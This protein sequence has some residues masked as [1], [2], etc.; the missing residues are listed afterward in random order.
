MWR[1]HLLNSFIIVGLESSRKVVPQTN[2]HCG[3][4]ASEKPQR[5]KNGKK[6]VTFGLGEQCGLG[7]RLLGPVRWST[8]NT[9][10]RTWLVD[11]PTQRSA[12]KFP[13]ERQPHALPSD[14]DVFRGCIGTGGPSPVN[15]SGACSTA[16]P[17]MGLDDTFKELDVS[18]HWVV[19]AIEPPHKPAR[20]SQRAKSC[21]SNSHTSP[22]FD[23]SVNSPLRSF[24]HRCFLRE[25]AGATSTHWHTPRSYKAP[26]SRSS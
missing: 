16:D 7:R 21:G 11:R 17:R 4:G 18:L 10:V 12:T 14:A 1:A 15:D 19:F 8:S 6:G 2:Q 25:C 3:G 20:G 9:V 23:Y 13:G 24:C 26:P 5:I 22:Y